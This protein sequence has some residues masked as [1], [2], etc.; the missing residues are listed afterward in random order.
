[1]KLL[2]SDENYVKDGKKLLE[3]IGWLGALLMGV[4]THDHPAVVNYRNRTAP[5][6][7]FAVGDR[8]ECNI[9][10]WVSG[11]VVRLWYIEEGLDFPVPYQ[12]LL[13]DGALIYAPQDID[14][15]VRL[16]RKGTVPAS[17]GD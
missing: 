5:P 2:Q 14:E 10:E 1:M 9:G 11:K 4:I 17:S 16:V 7:R 15:T 6:L 13:D 8:V 3:E 12:V